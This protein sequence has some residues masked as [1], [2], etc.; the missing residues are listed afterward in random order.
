MKDRVFSGRDVAAALAAAGQALGLPAETLRYVVLEAGRPAGLGVSPT[1][2][3]I[4]VL[5]DDSPAPPRQ[6]P[7]PP[8]P[9]GDPR[10]GIRAVVRALGEAAGIDLAAEIEEGE[11]GLRV[12]LG[13]KD[14]GFF[15]EEGGEVLRATEHLLMRMFARDVAPRGLLVDCEGYREQRDEALRATAL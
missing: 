5:L 1:P 2:A 4:A 11:Q 15:L 3:R 12:R 6:E 10:A 14:R 8:R 9:S 13:G 7:A